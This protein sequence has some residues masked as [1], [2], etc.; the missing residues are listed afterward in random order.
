M[1]TYQESRQGEAWHDVSAQ[2]V[3]AAVAKDGMSKDHARETLEQG[4]TIAVTFASYQLKPKSETE[5]T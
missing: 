1:S 3:F 2:H 5:S 4:Y